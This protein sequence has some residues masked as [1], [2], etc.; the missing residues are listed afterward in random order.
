MK[1]RLIKSIVLVAAVMIMALICTFVIVGATEEETYTIS[2]SVNGKIVKTEDFPK[3]QAAVLPSQPISK[4]VEG[5]KF[6]GWYT[7]TGAVYTVRADGS[8]IVLAGQ[9]VDQVVY[10]AYGVEV[11]TEADFLREVKKPNSYVKLVKNDITVDE[12][13]TLPDSGLTIIDLNGRV[14]NIT[15]K[16]VAFKGTNASLHIVNSGAA[17]SGKIIHKG[18]FTDKYLMDSSL[19]TLSPTLRADT[20][21]RLFPRVLIKS[22]VGIFDIVSDMT[23]SKYNYTLDIGATVEGNFLVRSYGIRNT[24][25]TT[26][27]YS[28]ITITGLYVFEDRGL[29]DA[30]NL[31][32]KMP[33]GKLT[34]AADTFITNEMDRY[35]VYITGGSFS[36]DLN[37]LY[38]HYTFTP[39][40]DGRY[41]FNECN[42]DDVLISMTADCDKAGTV[43]FKCG[44]C[45]VEHTDPSGA[46]GHSL[47]TT[48]AQETVTTVNATEPGYYETV[49]SRCDYE[50]R[51]Y[52]Y[53]SPL[54]VYVAIKYRL[55]TGEDRTIKVKADKIFGI[56]GTSLKSFEPSILAI[57]YGVL[58]PQI[59]SVELP[60]GITE[61]VGGL[62][63]GASG[64]EPQGAL[65][66]EA[67]IEELVLPMS[68]VNI[69][70]TAFADM[71]SLKTVKG[72]EHISGKI[73]ERAFEQKKGNIVYIEK[74]EI[75]AKEIGA[76]AFYNFTMISLTL[77]KNVTTISKNA[78]GM[79]NV[80]EESK[81][82]EIFSEKNTS[83]NGVNLKGSG[84]VT[85]EDGQQFDGKA[86]VFLDHY[87]DEENKVVIE[88]TCLQEG[89]EILTCKNCGEV[90][91]ENFVDMVDHSYVEIK[92]PTT[93]VAQGYEGLKCTVCE[94]I[95]IV[96]YYVGHVPVHDFT[97]KETYTAQDD[98]DNT[99][100]NICEDD[101]LI[102]GTCRCGEMDPNENNWERKDAIGDHVLDERNP[103]EYVGATCDRKGYG[104]YPC[105]NCGE[106]YRLTYEATGN[107]LYITDHK[108][109]VL[110]TCTTAGKKAFYCKECG[111]PKVADDV[112]N[113]ENHEWEKDKNGNLLWT[114]KVEATTEK[115]GK[116]ENK[117][118]GCG[119]VQSKGIPVT[120]EQTK[121]VDKLYMILIIA[122]GAVVAVGLGITLYF[123]L[124]K[125]KA[126]AGYKYKFNT[127]GKK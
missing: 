107:H 106:S 41:K 122:G 97:Y 60:L 7:D 110:S 24:T 78:F 125:K 98:I 88:P 22:N 59:Y 72:L 69:G 27:L 104:V 81:L 71:K 76:N 64:S 34:L 109:T 112:L 15:S 16:D 115:A 4:E 55:T 30:I 80:A 103:L 52:F 54:D 26:N 46:L 111:T 14:L 45:G 101:Y 86:I 123:T 108:N 47:V 67:Y 79:T 32:F 35:N 12:I 44:H 5:K 99:D 51:E 85:V 105:I 75:N 56:E 21:I 23:G 94:Y 87:F 19:F 39:G 93:C 9:R 63:S 89:Y 117:C 61:V 42:H 96:D 40:S 1:R 10:E 121:D 113:P 43:T 119:K 29:Y 65:Y 114:T 74:M 84:L 82:K 100:I 124:F 127:L 90:R 58:R 126:S 17:G 20:Q 2:Y 62:S 11:S 66:G 49:C 118:L 36:K 3:T 92:V 120:E 25:V 50:A 116:A 57:E 70:A 53:P 102:V 83:K 28:D 6:F 8:D 77:G 37:G 13:I 73:G 18:E 48:L 31:T 68:L 91:N 95:E 38:P 33:D